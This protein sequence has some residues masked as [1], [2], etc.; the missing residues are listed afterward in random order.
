M[1][2][3]EKRKT[4]RHLQGL[5]TSDGRGQTGQIDAFCWNRPRL[6]VW[7]RGAAAPDCVPKTGV[8]E[9]TGKGAAHY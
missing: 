4:M 6:S 8:N 2:A 7:Y 5:G 3:T 9:R 1:T